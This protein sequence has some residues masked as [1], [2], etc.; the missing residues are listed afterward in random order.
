MEEENKAILAT[1]MDRDRPAS[2]GAPTTC[3]DKTNGGTC[4]E[5]EKEGETAEK[6]SSAAVIEG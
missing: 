3:S 6:K 1:I 5:K 2:T 4:E